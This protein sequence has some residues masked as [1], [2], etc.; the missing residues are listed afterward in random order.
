MILYAN[1]L[2]FIWI[3]ILH[4][5]PIPSTS[6]SGFVAFKNI[7]IKADGIFLS[8]IKGKCWKVDVIN[9]EIY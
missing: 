6:A 7:M 2:T 4:Q 9:C 3:H 8:L 5:F 1:I